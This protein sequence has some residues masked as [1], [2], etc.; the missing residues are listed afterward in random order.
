MPYRSVLEARI[1]QRTTQAICDFSM[2]E[3][4]D[5]ILV[6]LSGGAD[7]WALLQMLATLQQRAPI[8]FSFEAVT[9]D[10]GFKDFRHDLVAD[11]CRARGWAHQ[12]VFTRIAEQVDRRMEA[13][14]TPCALCSRLR[15]GVL[16]RVARARG[17]TKLA[18]GHHADDVIETLLLNLIFEGALKALPARLAAPDGAFSTIRPLVYVFKHDLSAY[19]EE[20]RLPV[21]AGAC[22]IGSNRTSERLRVRQLLLELER[23]H[24]GTK[25]SLLR[26]V[27]NV[28]PADL[29]DPAFVL[30]A[31]SAGTEAG[32][33]ESTSDL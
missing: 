17:A 12:V 21:I 24:R 16:S 28:K 30:P 19:T 13:G 10:A 2:V 32:S 18:L 26:A 20:S 22:P 6:A 33:T 9:V 14:Q 23:E 4:G 1:A 8:R 27:R 29:L 3:T 7:S 5:H 15:R 11:A 25:A 31:Q